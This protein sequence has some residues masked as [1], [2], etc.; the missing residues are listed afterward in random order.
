MRHSILCFIVASMCMASGSVFAQVEWKVEDGGNGH[1][2]ELTSLRGGWAAVE[3]EAV[4]LGGHLVSITS[5]E[6]QQFIVDNFLLSEPTH[7]P[8]NRPNIFW[9]GLWDETPDG[10]FDGDF[11]WSDGS[12]L[13]YTNW[14]PGEASNTGGDEEYVVINW[15]Q[16]EAEYDPYEYGRWNDIDSPFVEGAN[17]NGAYGIMEFVPPL[18]ALVD[19][20]PDT[21]N[22]K[23]KGKWI[24]AYI[25][26]GE[27]Y[28]VNDINIDS[29]AITSIEGNS[30]PPG[31]TQFADVDNYVPQVGDRDEDEIPDLTVKFDRQALVDNLCLDD[32]EIVIEF[33][34]LDGTAFAGQDIIRVIDRGK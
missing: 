2:Y 10:L 19:I 15:D 17:W 29:I 32:V 26:L 22:V 7:L 8:N 28:S 34:L 9:I 21:L 11:A 25:T 30:C 3:A 24:T 18:E 12:A 27:G 23:S 33:S 20:D 31:Y 5:A 14:A 16:N 1:T 6:E 4:S 13:G